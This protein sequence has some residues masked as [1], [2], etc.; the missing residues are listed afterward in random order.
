MEISIT[1]NGIMVKE[2]DKEIL[3]IV[4]EINIKVNG[5][6]ILKMVKEHLNLYKDNI[7]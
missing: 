7:I 6:K 4:M 3:N 5:K 2:T 1:E